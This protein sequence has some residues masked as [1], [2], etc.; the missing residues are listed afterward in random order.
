V[1]LAN[2]DSRL[3]A[4][5]QANSAGNTAFSDLTK[6]VDALESELG[7]RLAATSKSLDDMQKGLSALQQAKP[8]SVD[9]A[10]LEDEI[11]TLSSRLDAVAAGASSADA[12]AISANLATVEKTVGDLTDRIAAL[13][14]RTSSTEASLK[15]LAADL[16]TEKSAIDRA[17]KAPSARAIAAAMQLPLLISALEADFGAGRPYAADLASLTAALPE[18]RVPAAL[19]A[20]ATTGLPAPDELMQQLR[21]A[22][23]DMLAARPDGTD[24]SWQGG[25][26]DWFRNVLALRR[27][28]ETSGDGPDAVL[29]RLEGAIG[30]HDFAGA[31]TLLDSLPPAMRQAAGKLDGNLHALADAEMF[32]ATLRRTALAP[33]AGAAQ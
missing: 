9:L 25:L 8:A 21:T 31:V 24:T 30:R 29:S 2:V 32:L 19:G 3:A 6:R 33:A 18:T 1:R 15:G 10:P 28:G 7:T 5:E 12:G 14:G 4:L 20:A 16:A 23:P 13:E 26:A 22:V 17:A 27:Q 11:K